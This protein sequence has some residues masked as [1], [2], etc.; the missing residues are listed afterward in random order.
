MKFEKA[1]VSIA[2]YITFKGIYIAKTNTYY[3]CDVYHKCFEDK[4]AV[5][6]VA[7]E[8]RDSPKELIMMHKE[9]GLWKF[10]EPEHYSELH[11]ELMHLIETIELKSR[12]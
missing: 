2:D 12:S 3:L 10:S 7:V 11:S 8:T 6:Y 5:Y 4:S 9:D 1:K